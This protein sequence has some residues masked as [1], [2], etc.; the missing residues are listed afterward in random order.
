[1]AAEVLVP[2]LATI[3]EDFHSGR[4][5]T[6]V[7]DVAQSLELQRII[8]RPSLASPEKGRAALDH[9]AGVAQHVLKIL[10]ETSNEG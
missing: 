10:D 8:G 6:E 7:T 3:N 5:L 1:M 9:L 2:L 4:D